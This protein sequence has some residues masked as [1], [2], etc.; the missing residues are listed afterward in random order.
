MNFGLWWK[1]QTCRHK[2]VTVYPLIVDTDHYDD[3][4]RRPF[5]TTTKHYLVIE[6]YDCGAVRKSRV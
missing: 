5:A 4:R 2:N 6:C 3:L 1:Q